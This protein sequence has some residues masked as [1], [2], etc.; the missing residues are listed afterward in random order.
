M[1]WSFLKILS[2]GMLRIQFRVQVEGSFRRLRRF[3]MLISLRDCVFYR[4]AYFVHLS[5]SFFA[6][7]RCKR[8]NANYKLKSIKTLES[9]VSN[10]FFLLLQFDIRGP[11]SFNQNLCFQWNESEICFYRLYVWHITRGIQSQLP[12]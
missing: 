8:T 3:R 4:L 12:G 6:T 11:S 9:K 7:P 10:L 1:T 5:I 2:T